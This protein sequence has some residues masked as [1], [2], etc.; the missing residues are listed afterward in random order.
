[1][2]IEHEAKVLDV[3]LDEIADVILRAGGRRVATRQGGE[4]PPVIAERFLPRLV[5]LWRD[6]GDLGAVVAVVGLVAGSAG[7]GGE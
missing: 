5:R 7:L 6:V 1:M 3:A 2:T 4:S